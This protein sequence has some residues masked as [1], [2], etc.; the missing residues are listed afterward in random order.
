MDLSA[1]VIYR[2]DIDDA[3][4]LLQR[5]RGMLSASAPLPDRLLLSHESRTPAM[6]RA[7]ALLKAVFYAALAFIP[8][9]TI[10]AV[11]R[12]LGVER[13]PLGGI[14]AAIVLGVAM[15]I[16]IKE[17]CD[18]TLAWDETKWLDFT[19]RV[20]RSHKQYA[21]RSMPVESSAIPFA[22]LVLVFHYGSIQEGIHSDLE[23]CQFD[24]LGKYFS[25]PSEC[26]QKVFYSDNEPEV[27]N[28]A[29]KL[30][31]RWGIDCWYYA[32]PSAGGLQRTFP[33]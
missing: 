33:P 30:A 21:H 12:A 23:L 2:P 20:W 4:T 17:M 26:T 13:Q 25:A 1:S 18:R 16:F 32:E 5:V 3:A 11:F 10:A 28:V 7:H 9:L 15:N 19:D 8:V 29:I 31:E 27:R 24:D 14:A 6:Q 22:S